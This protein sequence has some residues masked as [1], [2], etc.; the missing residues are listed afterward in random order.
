M[1]NGKT[2][3]TLILMLFIIVIGLSCLAFLTCGGSSKSESDSQISNKSKESVKQTTQK[4]PSGWK[5]VKYE[6]WS[7][8]FPSNW[9]GA[10]DGGVWWPGEGSMRMGRPA[11]SVHCGAIPLMPNQNFEDRIKSHIGGTPQNRQNVSTSGMKGFICN[12]ERHE[13]K[14]LGHFL[15]EK[16]GGT[17]SMIHFVDCQAPASDFDKYKADFEKIINSTKK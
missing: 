5:K 15:E 17:M 14:H 6:G 13:K 9:N 3:R 8:S 1:G 10:E 7:I 2:M 16:I 4:S 12:W 11:L